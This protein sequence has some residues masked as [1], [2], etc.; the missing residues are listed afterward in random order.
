MVPDWDAIYQSLSAARPLARPSRIERRAGIEVG[1][2]A[3]QTE[4]RH[5]DH[6]VGTLEDRQL[7]LAALRVDFDHVFLRVDDHGIKI[8]GR[9][10]IA[11]R[12]EVDRSARIR[13]R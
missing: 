5:L 8:T 4:F 13:W 7:P 6:V 11:A 12:F 10:A 1:H 3:T 2:H 9:F